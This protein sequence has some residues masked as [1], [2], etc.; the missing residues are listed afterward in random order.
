MRR[1]PLVAWFRSSRGET[2][3][4]FTFTLVNLHLD[5]RAADQEIDHLGQLFRSIRNDGR[6][7]DDVI[8]AGDF[9]AGD[10]SLERLNETTGLIRLVSNAST[11]TRLSQQYKRLT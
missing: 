6:G 3:K 8:I 1:E 7:E 10:V 5:S 11:N 4:A 2:N 9:N